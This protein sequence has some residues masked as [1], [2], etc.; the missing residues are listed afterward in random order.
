[1]IGWRP[2]LDTDNLNHFSSSHELALVSKFIYLYTVLTVRL[3]RRWWWD[4]IAETPYP[5]LLT[6]SGVENSRNI[7]DSSYKKPCQAWDLCNNCSNTTNYFPVDNGLTAAANFCDNLRRRDS[8]WC[9]LV[10]WGLT[11]TDRRDNCSLPHCG[12]WWWTWW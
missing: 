12:K 8:N 11:P 7:S 9:D 2:G 1:M 5:C 10:P 3:E 4:F 6:S